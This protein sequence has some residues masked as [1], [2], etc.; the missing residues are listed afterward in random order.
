VTDKVSATPAARPTSAVAS[1]ED[2]DV[3]VSRSELTTG[4]QAPIDTERVAKVR[5]AIADG[6]YPLVPAKIADAMIAASILLRS[7]Q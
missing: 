2:K 7:S 5:Q 1:G 4:G 6:S 3:E